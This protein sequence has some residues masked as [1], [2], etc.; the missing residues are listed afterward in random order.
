MEVRLSVYCSTYHPVVV[1]ITL[2]GHLSCFVTQMAY[3][4]NVGLVHPLVVLVVVVSGH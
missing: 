2:G 4:R 3:Q 1:E